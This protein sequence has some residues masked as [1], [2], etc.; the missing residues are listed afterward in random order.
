[1]SFR[2]SSSFERGDVSSLMERIRAGATV[3][4]VETSEHVL[5]QSQVIVPIL[6]GALHASGNT[7]LEQSSEGPCGYV[8]YDEPYAGYVEFGTSRMEPQP[9]LRPAL[10]AA[11]DLFLDNVKAG[12]QNAI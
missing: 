11:H 9:Y 2:A 4:V 5:Q 3:A 10:D 8:N 6:T 1:M 7:T 12:V